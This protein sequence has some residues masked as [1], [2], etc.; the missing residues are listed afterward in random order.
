MDQQSEKRTNTGNGPQQGERQEPGAART[1]AGTVDRLAERAHDALD[2]AH[3]RASRV[4]SS[5]S[6]L[7][8][9]ASDKIEGATAS[10]GRMLHSAADRVR[11]PG[12]R[13]QRTS[14]RTRIADGL[15]RAGT[16]LQERSPSELR[17]DVE[18]GVRRRP[19]R[20]VLL[21]LSVGYLL[22]RALR[23]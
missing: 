7:A 16:Y 20:A 5:A 21:S 17:S 11:E 2:A 8:D 19:M 10:V 3:E 9:Q 13:G 12:Q 23:R 1:G 14:A 18:A 22:A 6:D 15:D 4:A